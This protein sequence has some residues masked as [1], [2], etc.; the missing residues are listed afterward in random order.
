MPQAHERSAVTYGDATTLSGRIGAQTNRPSG[1]I[2]WL[3]AGL[4]LAGLGGLG[5]ARRRR[6]G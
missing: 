1:A 3:A 5:L 6:R 4:M 2:G